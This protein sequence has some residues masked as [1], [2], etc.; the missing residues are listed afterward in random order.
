MSAQEG[1]KRLLTTQEIRARWVNLGAPIVPEPVS[2]PIIE[3]VIVDL[4]KQAHLEAL[5][6]AELGIVPVQR[7]TFS[8]RASSSSLPASNPQRYNR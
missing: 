8:D 5:K 7:S 1:E 2:P 4:A 3:E 6:F